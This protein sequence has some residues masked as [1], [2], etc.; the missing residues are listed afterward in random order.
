MQREEVQREEEERERGGEGIR[1]LP[2]LN[3]RVVDSPL[4]LVPLRSTL[5]RHRV[6]IVNAFFS[7]FS[8]F[9]SLLSLLFLSLSLSSL[10]L[11][12]SRGRKT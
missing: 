12:F 9:L 4:A 11:S 3:T 5:L 10:S 1:R 7:L 8:L 6:A 2:A